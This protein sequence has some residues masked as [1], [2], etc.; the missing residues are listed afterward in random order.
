MDLVK[1]VVQL[2]NDIPEMKPDEYITIV[3][4]QRGILPFSLSSLYS[5][6]SSLLVNLKVMNTNQIQTSL[7]MLHINSLYWSLPLS[8]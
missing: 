3:K 5:F 1:V 7:V 4:V 8:L 6:G 2:K